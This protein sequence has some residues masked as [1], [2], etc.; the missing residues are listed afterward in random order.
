MQQQRKQ[1]RSDCR[2]D[3]RYMKQAHAPHPPPTYP[4]AHCV[5]MPA[6]TYLPPPNA[7]P[8]VRCAMTSSRRDNNYTSKHIQLTISSA[9]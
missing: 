1:L 2:N 9:S 6:P 4:P 5:R 3:R 7:R 8:A